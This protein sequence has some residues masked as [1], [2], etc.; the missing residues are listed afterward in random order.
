MQKYSTIL[1]R[2]ISEE[3]K[4]ATDP[5][6]LTENRTEWRQTVRKRMEF[7]EQWE[8]SKGSREQAIETNKT[9][10]LKSLTC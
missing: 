2:L 3:G 10:Q 1:A 8:K 9:K 4:D 7:L 5:D 6:R